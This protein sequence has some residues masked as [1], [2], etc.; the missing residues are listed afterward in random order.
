MKPL[1]T[2]LINTLK[3]S[4]ALLLNDSPYPST[5]LEKKKQTNKQSLGYTLCDCLP[6]KVCLSLSQRGADLTPKMR[7]AKTKKLR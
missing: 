7:K 5:D 4:Y 2:W 1:A 6:T 3:I